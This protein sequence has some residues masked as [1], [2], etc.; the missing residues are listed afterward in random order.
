MAGVYAV[1]E[2]EGAISEAD[3]LA[4]A[5]TNVEKLQGVKTDALQSDLVA[6]L[7]SDLLDFSKVVAVVSPRRGVMDII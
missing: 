1:P 2:S 6:T 3:T 4:L 7:G 5:S